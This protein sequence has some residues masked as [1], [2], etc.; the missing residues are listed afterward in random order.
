MLLCFCALYFVALLVIIPG[1]HGQPARWGSP[2][3]QPAHRLHL[4]CRPTFICLAQI[5]SAAAAV[6][7]F[8]QFASKSADL[9]LKY[10]IDTFGNRQSIGR[11]D[12]DR[13]RTASVCQSGVATG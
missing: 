3:W 5:N 2:F 13:L 8:C 4:T 6:E 1:Y 10:H 9:F 7:Y 12:E 11:K